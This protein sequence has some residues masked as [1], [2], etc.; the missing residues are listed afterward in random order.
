MS[1]SFSARAKLVFG[2]GGINQ[3]YPDEEKRWSQFNSDVEEYAE[4]G[5]PMPERN[6][7]SGVPQTLPV[8]FGPF[9]VDRSPNAELY[10]LVEPETFEIYDKEFPVSPLYIDLKVSV[11]DRTQRYVLAEEKYAQLETLFRLFQEGHVFIR[12]HKMWE[13]IDEAP[14]EQDI[15]EVYSGDLQFSDFHEQP[16]SARIFHEQ[17]YDLSDDKLNSFVKFFDLY[18]DVLQDKPMPIQLA[19]SRFSS[20]YEKRTL[21]DRLLELMIAMEALFAVRGDNS[22]QIPLRCANLLF[23]QGEAREKAFKTL[24]GVYND[25]SRIVHGDQLTTKYTER[26]VNVFEDYVRKSLIRFLDDKRIGKPIT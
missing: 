23:P 5:L 3:P 15:W 10:P 19:L 17:P 7:S 2:I 11:E 24:R 22:Y 1:E 21:G 12:L 16:D 13:L 25:R 4:K 6:W 26:D 14:T 8:T 18:W 20:S 9:T